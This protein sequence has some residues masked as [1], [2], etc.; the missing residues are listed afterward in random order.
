MTT[1]IIRRLL[2]LIPVLVVVAAITFILMHNTPAGHG[3]RSEHPQ[4]DP[5]P[6]RGSTRPMAWI[7]RSAPVHR[8]HDRRC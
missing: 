6:R 2:W 7:S 3:P 1:Y 5:P 8:L 4:V